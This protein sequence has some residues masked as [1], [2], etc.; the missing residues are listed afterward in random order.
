MNTEEEKLLNLIA[1]LDEMLLVL[2]KSNCN[3]DGLAINMLYK[4]IE[5]GILDNI[6]NSNQHQ[7]NA[8]MNAYNFRFYTDF[9]KDRELLRNEITKRLRANKLNKIL[10]K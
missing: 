6:H 2:S 10:D 9:N 1:T 3:N 8:I 4:K 7:L 5:D